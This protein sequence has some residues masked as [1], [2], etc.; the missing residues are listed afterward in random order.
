MKEEKRGKVKHLAWLADRGLQL[1]PCFAGRIPFSRCQRVL[2]GYTLS[3]VLE[4]DCW[5]E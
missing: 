1:A 2:V 5:L 4:G 3:D